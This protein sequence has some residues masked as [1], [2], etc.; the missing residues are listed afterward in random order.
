MSC[1][2]GEAS[3]GGIVFGAI[4]PHGHLA[5]PEACNA[6]ERGLA[7]ATQE[8]MAEL[9]QRFAAARPDATILFTPHNVHVEGH[10]AVLVAGQLKGSLSDWTE[11][12]IELHCPTD[13]DLARGALD[14]LRDAGI[15]AIG[16]SYGGNDAAQ[17]TAPMDWGALIPLWFMGG[18]AEPQ[19][20]VVV[21]SPAHGHAHRE[22]GPYGFDPA[23]AEYDGRVADLVR[24]DR[25]GELLDL[26]P[27]LVAAAKADSYWQMLMLHGALSA[28]RG[29]WRGGVLSYE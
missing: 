21:I 17:A 2:S 16:V 1:S 23:A 11:A 13:R 20:P 27:G 7:T 19:V 9:G 29:G 28:A 25:L 24:A 12:K 18:R 10:L 3:M 4:A 8:A 6:E 22:D 5:I 26:R 15:P 14:A